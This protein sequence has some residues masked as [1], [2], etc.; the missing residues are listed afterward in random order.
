[1]AKSTIDCFAVR[2]KYCSLAKKVRLISQANMRLSCRGGERS[3]AEGKLM[4]CMC[5]RKWHWQEQNKVWWYNIATTFYEYKRSCIHMCS[6]INTI[7]WLTSLQRNKHTMMRHES[8]ARASLG[9]A[10]PGGHAGQ[11]QTKNQ[12]LTISLLCISPYASN[13]HMPPGVVTELF[14]LGH[15]CFAWQNFCSVLLAF[16]FAN[17][18]K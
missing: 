8:R 16:F 7:S 9:K 6:Q 1:M 4:S 17:G 14:L 12:A 13:Q 3:K 2:E 18:S 11:S 10:R 15:V 5:S